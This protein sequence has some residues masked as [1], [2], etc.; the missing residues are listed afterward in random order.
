M[1]AGSLEFENRLTE[2]EAR[3]SPEGLLKRYAR[4]RLSFFWFRQIFVLGGAAVLFLTGHPLAGG[5]ALLTL[6]LGD[7]LDCAYLAGV[8]RRLAAGAP[9]KRLYFVSTLTAEVQALTT[10]LLIGLPIALSGGA[11]TLAFAFA[12]I[13]GGGIN[14]SYLYSFHRAATLVRLAVLLASGVGVM[15][16]AWLAGSVSPE[17]QLYGLFAFAMTLFLNYTFLQHSRRSIAHK[18]QSAHRLLEQSQKL[19]LTNTMLHAHQSEMRR[20]ALVAQ[21]A[22]DSVF[23]ADPEGRILWVNAA[24]T[25]LTGYSAQEAVGQRPADLLNAPT[26]DPA[27]SEAIRTAI[28]QGRPLRSEIL[29]ARKDGSEVWVETNQV[30]VLDANGAVEMVIAVERDIS[31]AKHH[32]EEL[33]RAKHSAE[34]GERAKAQFLATMSHEIRTPMN[35]IIGM[36]DLL[37][38]SGLAKEQRS[39]VETIRYSAEAL[40]RIIN[41]ILDFS[42]LDAG[43]SVICPVDF[44]LLPCVESALSILR[45]KALE[46]QIY[47]ELTCATP[48]PPLVR[49]D[50]GRIRQ[51]ILNIVGNAIKFTQ[52]GGVT[53]DLSCTTSPEGHS[54]TLAVTDTGIGIPADRV[55]LIFDQFSQAD[56]A[57]TREFGGTGLGLTISRIL[58]REMGGDIAIRSVLGEGSTFTITLK[59]AQALTPAPDEAQPREAGSADNVIKLPGVKALVAEDNLTNQLLMKSFLKSTEMDVIYARNGREAVRLARRHAPRVIFMDMS[60]PEM[61]GLSATRKIRADP[62]LV[63]PTIVALTA[64]VYASDKAACLSAGMDGFLSKPL[65]RAELMGWLNQI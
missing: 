39:Y 7:L 15:A 34:E 25:R 26:T 51:I 65:K 28:T 30:P 2:F 11:E 47:V 58:A 17:G 45:P 62:S 14:S 9:V 1:R 6:L 24:F 53:L 61:D 38:D 46:K 8:P 44:E 10:V 55:D 12:F 3:Q 56:G 23:V 48:L 16:H 37:R 59:L 5:V 31:A 19:A 52:Q 4:Q 43:K 32:E 40:M 13:A 42:K 20:L 57:I 21:N 27:T 22:N 18:T 35:G 49:G 64:N 41:D 50:D 29:N 36:A 33:A 54:L 63:Q 60:M